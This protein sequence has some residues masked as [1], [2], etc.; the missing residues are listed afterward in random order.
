M[1]EVIVLG[2]NWKLD[3]ILVDLMSPAG[4]ET[5]SITRCWCTAGWHS[6]YC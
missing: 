4:T 2:W 5:Y 6:A 3:R 1:N